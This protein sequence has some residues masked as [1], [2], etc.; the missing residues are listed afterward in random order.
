[1]SKL[2]IRELIKARVLL[3]TEPH[4]SLD[5]K[6]LLVV[7]GLF[8]VFE[9]FACDVAFE[10]ADDL[11]FAFAFDGAALDVGAGSGF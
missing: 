4:R 3:I 10:A 8:E 9:Y 6:L 2:E 11:S 5:M 1:M 7:K